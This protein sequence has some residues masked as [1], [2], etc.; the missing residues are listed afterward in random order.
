MKTKITNHLY[1]T[2]MAFKTAKH[3]QVYYDNKLQEFTFTPDNKREIP[4]KPLRD[5][6][7]KEVFKMLVDQELKRIQSVYIY[8]KPKSKTM[9]FS[10]PTKQELDD[11]GYYEYPI[12]FPNVHTLTLPN[13]K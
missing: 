12:T 10:F 11:E 7:V 4:L 5:K 1:D 3:T 6:R 2:F 9:G 13:L 8:L